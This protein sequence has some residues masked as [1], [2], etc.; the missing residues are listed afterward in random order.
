MKNL[1]LIIALSLFSLTMAAQTDSTETPSSSRNPEV[2][3]KLKKDIDK[4]ESKFK[5]N[6]KEMDKAEDN[7]KKLQKSIEK[8]NAQ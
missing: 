4:N 1:F 6:K 3:K 2:I 7:M 5:K 8:L